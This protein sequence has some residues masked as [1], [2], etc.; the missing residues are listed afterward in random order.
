V[1]E[2]SRWIGAVPTKQCDVEDQLCVDVDC[3]VQP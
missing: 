1:Q 3:S 2:C